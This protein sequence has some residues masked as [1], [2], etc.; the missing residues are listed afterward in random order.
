ML[1]YSREEIKIV[2]LTLIQNPTGFLPTH[3]CLTKPVLFL[4]H[5]VAPLAKIVTHNAGPVAT[6]ESA[7]HLMTLKAYPSLEWAQR[8]ASGTVRLIQK[9]SILLFYLP[10]D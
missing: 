9:E 2:L 4:H 8:R 3:S 6:T 10:L 1:V 5:V 7:M